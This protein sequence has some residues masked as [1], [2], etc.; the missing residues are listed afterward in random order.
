[1]DEA[2]D[3]IPELPD[4]IAGLKALVLD[5]HSEKKVLTVRIKVLEEQLALLR[6]KQFGA[7]SEKASPDQISLFNEAEVTAKEPPPAEDEDTEDEIT[8]PEH[9]RKKSGRKPIPDNLPRVRVE[10][11]IPEAEKLCPC[12]SG[13]ERPRIG[14]VIT[15]QY[16]IIPAQIQVL[17][18]V[19]FKYGPCAC[20][21]GVFPEAQACEQVALE[22][23]NTGAEIAEGKDA[24]PVCQVASET[25]SQ[26]ARVVIVAPLPAQPIPKS[27]A[28]PGLLAYIATS[29]FVDGLPLYRLETMLERIGVDL[30]RGTM[31]SWMIHISVSIVPL[32]NLLNDTQNDYDVLQMD[33]TT[34]QV[35]KEDGRSAQSKSQM[36]VRRGGPPDKPVILFDYDPSRSGAVPFRLLADY[37]GYLQT[38]GYDGYG[39]VAERDGII[40]IGC[41]AHA[42]RKF[43]EA[44]KAHAAKQSG[45][46][47]LAAEALAL[48]Q[49]IYRVEKS[50]R[51][52]G[53]TPEQRHQLRQ[54]KE[55]PIWDELR[56]W[57]DRVRDQAPP[58]TLIGKAIAYLDREWS[59]LIRVLDDGRLE[60]DN[61]LCENAIRP[62]VMGRKAWLFADTPAG[63]TASARLF[64]L[65]ETCKANGR[66]PFA[67]LRHVFTELPKA[68]TLADFEALLPWNFQASAASRLAA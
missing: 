47:G 19:R 65:I 50:A 51:E 8:V 29:K 20:C 7:R 12:G 18:H 54:E 61:N 9:K 33:E 21:Q 58:L 63:A 16:D 66:E 30:P 32:I 45:R 41:L 26:T 43:D 37:H 36:W 6:H 22:S 53:L 68:T 31:A 40:H 35:L 27:N 23:A 52:A 57:L 39:R 28:S 11:D 59:R 5:Y 56:K 25:D 1:M 14:E 64:S 15:E 17:Q 67:Y 42:R 44:A 48:I 62:F 46:V 38:D 60:V 13:N 55:R 3:Q 4:D 24:A 2:A 34:L 10:H 49:K